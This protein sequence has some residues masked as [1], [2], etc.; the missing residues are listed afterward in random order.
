MK[1]CLNSLIIGKLLTKAM[2]C[3]CRVF[4][5]VKINQGTAKCCQRY[6]DIKIFMHVAEMWPVQLC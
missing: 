1:I 6:K 2:R 4:L 5:L 3:Y